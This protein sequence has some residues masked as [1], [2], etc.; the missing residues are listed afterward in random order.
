[1]DAPIWLPAIYVDFYPLPENNRQISG[2]FPANFRPVSGF[3]SPHFLDFNWWMLMTQ[4]STKKDVE[5]AESVNT[6]SSRNG[7]WS[8]TYFQPPRLSSDVLCTWNLGWVIFLLNLLVWAPG[9]CSQVTY[10]KLL[11][12]VTWVLWIVNRVLWM[13]SLAS[14][15]ISELSRRVWTAM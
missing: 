9:F 6:L 15:G 7:V 5:E 14:C 1:M 4:V 2:K 10:K 13:V 3:C 12:A 8:E 11:Y